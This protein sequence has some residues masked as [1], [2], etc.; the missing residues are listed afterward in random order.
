MRR[1]LHPVLKQ[2]FLLAIGGAVMIGDVRIQP[3][4]DTRATLPYRFQRRKIR[5]QA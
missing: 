4:P 3:P 1:S 2:P 5:G